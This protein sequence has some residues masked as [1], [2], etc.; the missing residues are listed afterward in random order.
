MTYKQ[1]VQSAIDVQNACNLS[2]VARSLH[3]V[4]T[5]LFQQDKGTRWVN[6]HPAVTMYLCKMGE[7]NGADL[8]SLSPCY[9][10]AEKKCL[11]IIAAEK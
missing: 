7:L 9:E 6:S 11:E 3:E 2:G 10:V 8:C 4:T 5:V 1:A